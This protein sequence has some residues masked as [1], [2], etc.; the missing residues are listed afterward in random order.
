MLLGAFACIDGRDPTAPDLTR[1]VQFAVAPVFSGPAAAATA[2][3]TR[4]RV[5]ALDAETGEIVAVAEDDV[6]PVADQWTLVLTLEVSP[7][8]PLAIKLQAEVASS[9]GVVEWSGRTATINVQGGAEPLEVREIALFRGPLANLDVTALTIQNAPASLL[10]GEAGQ[11]SVDVSGGGSGT[12]VF[13]SSLDPAV[14]SVDDAGH[15]EALAPGTGRIRALAGAASAEVS[16]DVKEVVVPDAGEIEAGVSPMIDYAGDV[17]GTMGDATGAAAVS[18]SLTTLSTALA[19]GDGAAAVRAFGDAVAAWE[20]Y[21]AGTSLRT[22]DGPQLG[23]I[24]LSLII[25]ADA[26]GIPFG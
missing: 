22:L 23:L 15:V 10:E 1:S 18:S 21:G 8:V 7:G 26:L 19:S 5:T 3:L 25:T 12:R 9:D 20:G 4:L 2:A 16:L 13:F 11:L 6:D 17:V 14:V 24:Q